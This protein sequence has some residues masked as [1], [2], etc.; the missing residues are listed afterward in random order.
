MSLDVPT[1]ASSTRSA[2]RVNLLPALFA[3]L[4]LA[5]VAVLLIAAYERRWMDDDGFINLRIV[6]NLLHGYGPVFNLDERVE[7]GTSPLWVALLAVLGGLRIRLEHAAVFGGIVLAAFG[8]LL[9]VDAAARL[10]GP[11]ARS[12]AQ[13]WGRAAVPVGAAIFAA[14]PVA[15]DYASSGL[16][17]G[18]ALAWLGAS[19]DALAHRIAR[20]DGAGRGGRRL[21]AEAALIGLGPLVRPELALYTVAFLVP[22]AWSALQ[23]SES[24][25]S[26]RRTLAFIAISAAALPV[27][28]QIFR[29][30]YY[31][32]LL[33]NTALAK[34]AFSSNF[35]QGRCYFDNFFGTYRL[36]FALAAAGVFWVA[37]LHRMVTAG[38]WAALAAM[39]G[40]PLAATFHVA[41]IVSMGGDYMHG[42]L[43]VPAIFAALLPVMTVPASVP[44]SPL[45][46]GAFATGVVILAVWLPICALKLRVGVENVCMIG[47]ERGWYAREA[48]VDNPVELESYERHWFHSG[49]K[50]ALQRVFSACPALSSRSALATAASCR[51]VFLEENTTEIAPAPATSILAP[52]IDSRVGAVVGAGAIG[53]FGYLAPASVH[54]VDVHGLADPVVARFELQQ[55]GRPGHEK[56]LSA[57]W[58]LGRFAPA[59]EGEDAA[60]TAARHALACAPLSGLQGAIRGPLTAGGFLRNITHAWSFSRLRVAT[61]PFDAEQAFCNPRPLPEL[62]AGGGGGTAYRWR[63]S[64]GHAL[65][66]LRGA[67]SV[68]DRA[69]SRVQAV[70]GGSEDEPSPGRQ[71]VVGPAFGEGTDRPFELACPK[72]MAV[73]GIYGT[74]D[75]IVR[76]VGFI[77]SNAGGSVRSST[78]GEDRGND[79]S[80]ACPDRGA[81]VGIRGRSGSLVDA[82][83]VACAAP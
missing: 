30:G 26:A 5:P 80:L 36:G 33:P 40:P 66:A 11:V 44:R 21:A 16:E 46:R 71:A 63:C 38:R 13:R 82:V 49:A 78:G 50:T 56:R 45:V 58:T 4:A 29:M 53:M 32:S 61:D 28:Y 8:L 31:A 24:R 20:A 75:G 54:V 37:G 57:A 7:A 47:D 68:Q 9:G 83:G 39:H 19:Y 23:A 48:K 65:T 70:C 6:R 43:F 41:Y 64:A 27:G 14:L 35:A 69:I 59:A 34:E 76:S 74:A 15:W 2:G 67:Y 55:R 25:R 52:E 72:G 10:S 1:V 51:R 77:C 42:R 60:V 12:P 17:T 3:A 22:L 62:T 81:V 73:T 18:L 79:F